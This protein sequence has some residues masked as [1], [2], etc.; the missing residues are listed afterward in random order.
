MGGTGGERKEAVVTQP[1]N[2]G[3][4]G[5]GAREGVGHQTRQMK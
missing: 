4:R 2:K 1:D 3:Q 5:W